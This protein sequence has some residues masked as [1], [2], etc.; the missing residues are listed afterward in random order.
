MGLEET[1]RRLPI[2]DALPRPKDRA[3]L[4]LAPGE[5]SRPRVMA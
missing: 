2:V 3:I 4:P 5:A 1:R